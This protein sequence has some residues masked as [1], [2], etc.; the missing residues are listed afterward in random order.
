MIEAVQKKR[1]VIDTPLPA[2]G[3][4]GLLV[5]LKL[6]L[7]AFLRSPPGP[8]TAK[9][10]HDM[11]EVKFG[12]TFGKF[13]STFEHGWL[14]DWTP[15]NR[16]VFFRSA[17]PDM[18][19][20]H[21][22]G[23]GFQE[24]KPTDARL[25]MYHGY[26]P[27]QENE[28]ASFARF[29]FEAALP[30]EQLASFAADVLCELPVLSAYGGYF[31]QGRPSDQYDLRSAN[32]IFALSQRFWGVEVVDVEFSAEVMKQ[33]YKSVNWLTAIGAVSTHE[34]REALKHA[35]DAATT[36]S[37]LGTCTLLQA[38]EGPLLGDRNRDDD[39][40]AYQSV[41]EALLPLQVAE[42]PPF[43]GERWDETNTMAWLRRFTHP[44]EM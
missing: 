7:T 36:S 18:R 31:F 11:F 34:A 38:G 5:E 22:W 6:H 17:L 8:K 19:Q 44:S 39:L 14:S 12:D 13:R 30:P 2:G 3:G 1:S 16:D 27:H 9:R 35:R 33:G 32:R 41:A 15:R 37:D 24:E 20:R 10:L 21:I 25:M 43:R 23:Y 40:S 28:M 26:R 4:D 42:H 29:E